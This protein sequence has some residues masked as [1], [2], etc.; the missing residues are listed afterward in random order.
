MKDFVP[1][2]VALAFTCLFLVPALNAQQ[3]DQKKDYF[4]AP[5][6]FTETT[7]SAKAEVLMK[8]SSNIQIDGTYHTYTYTFDDLVIFS[9]K[10]NT[11]I[12]VKNSSGKK[13]WEGVLDANEY[14]SLSPGA[15]I[16]GLESS[17]PFSII[18][19]DPIR[20]LVLGFHAMNEQGRGVGNKFLTYMPKGYFGQERFVI[21]SYKERNHVQIKDLSSNSIRWEGILDKGEFYSSA[22]LN[23]SFLQVNGSEDLSVLSYGDQGYLIPAE[24]GLWAGKNF[25]GYA[26]FVGQWPND[27]NII[28]FK[29]NSDIH[30]KDLNT[31][32]IIWSG[33]LNQGEVKSIALT[34]SEKKEVFFEITSD[35]KVSASISPFT[36]YSGNYYHLLDCVDETGLRIG[37]M[38]YLPAIN[39]RLDFSSFDD[40]NYV[41][42]TN[43]KTDEVEWSG[44]LQAGDHTSLGTTNS[45]YKIEGTGKLTGSESYGGSAGGSFVPVYYGLDLPDLSLT[46][47]SISFSPD[48]PSYGDEVTITANIA[49]RGN[50]QTS[51]IE[52]G[53]YDG[54][55]DMG[56][57]Q[58]GSI[59]T[60]GTI[61]ANGGTGKASLKWTAPEEPEH[62]QIYVV[63]D[64]NDKIDESNESNNKAHQPLIPNEDL[65]PPLAVTIAAPSGIELDK[66]GNYTPDPI[67]ITA[68]ISNSGDGTALGVYAT[69]EL[70]NGLTLKSGENTTHSLGEM[71]VDGHSS[72]TWEVEATGESNG[73]LTYTVEVGADNAEVKN[74][75]RLLHVPEPPFEADISASWQNACVGGADLY[76]DRG[77]GFEKVGTTGDMSEPV[78]VTNL[79]KGTKI[80]AVKKIHTEEAVKNGHEEVDD[81]MFELWVDSDTM[82]KDG[83]YGSYTIT[84]ESDSY[85]LEME[86]PVF[87]Y[88]LVLSAE[89]DIS[90]NDYYQKLKE[91][92]QLASKYLYNVTDG[93]VSFNKIAIYDNKEKWSNSDINLY[94]SQHPNATVN[95]IHL[96]FIPLISKLG[97]L[98]L[99]K[100]WDEYGNNAPHGEWPNEQ[101]YYTTIVHEFGHYAFA[102]YDEYEDG[103]G[104]NISNNPDWIRG[105]SEH[106]KNYG[107]MQSQYTYE[108][109]SSANDYLIYYPPDTPKDEITEQRDERGMPCWDWIKQKLEGYYSD[110]DIK[111]PPDG[112]YPD[113]YIKDREGPDVDRIREETHVIDLRAQDKKTLSAFSS[114]INIV[115]NE[116][117]V[118]AAQVYIIDNQER[119]YLGK[120]NQEGYVDWPGAHTDVQIRAYKI[121]QGRMVKK[122]LTIKEAKE[123]YVVKLDQSLET[124]IAKSTQGDDPGIV[125]DGEATYSDSDNII[126]IDLTLLAD[127]SLSQNPEATIYYGSASETVSFAQEGSTNKYTGSVNM[128]ATVSG[129]D[130]TG[131]LDVSIQDMDSNESSFTSYFSL[132]SLSTTAL[133]R[134]FIR[135]FNLNV[136]EESV[137]S[138]QIGIAMATHTLP[139]NSTNQSLYPV[140]E[141]FSVTFENYHSFEEEAGMN[142]SYQSSEVEGLDE[143]SLGLYKWN[144][145]DKKWDLL[146]ESQTNP[147][148]NVVSALIQST[149]IY[150][151]FATELSDDETLPGKVE[152]LSAKTGEGQANINLSWTAPGDDGMTGQAI[153]Y[154]IRFNEAPITHKNWSECQELSYKPNP[155]PAGSSQQTSVKMPKSNKLY[156]FALKT[157]DEAGNKSKLSNYTEAISSVEPYTFSL[158]SPAFN[159]TVETYSPRFEW[160]NYS[161][162]QDPLYTLI[163]SEDDQFVEEERVIDIA[164]NRYDQETELK[165]GTTYYWKVYTIESSSDTAW[166]NQP[167]FKFHT[168][169]KY[170][171][172]LNV[173]PSPGGSVSGEG[174]YKEG[175]EITVSAEPDQGY[176]FESW[177]A[178]EQEVSTNKDYTFTVQDDISLTANFNMVSAIHSISKLQ[179]IEVYPNPAKSHVIVKIKG[180]RKKAEIELLNIEGKALYEGIIPPGMEK[181]QINLDHYLDGVYLIRLNTKD[182]V[183]TK[184][185]ILSRE[186]GVILI[187]DKSNITSFVMKSSMP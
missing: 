77:Q 11:E 126:S 50:N 76:V 176:E 13:I 180:L 62:R 166:S 115:Y 95:G 96:P 186:F 136:E 36:S 1:K 45:L 68:N 34:S 44:K 48:H 135:G 41:E 100:K 19:G 39:G 23:N 184:K 70:P 61:S 152:D 88:N 173:N 130:G 147:G 81:T 55:P 69:L 63:A 86:H 127:A 29:D 6:S 103:N 12:A 78:H 8:T 54:D 24:S 3:E 117:P 16:Y 89:F 71:P 66:E 145:S 110:V 118:P 132:Q 113:G 97:K 139:Y 128:D 51:Q 106:P 120:T 185:F 114:R 90:D 105:G 99:G 57:V 153:N 75:N 92:F 131:Y 181:Y 109:A 4:G 21:F 20:G 22:N 79:S 137:P 94:A 169:P 43:L 178:D 111:M 149:G 148:K 104:E 108:E 107:L 60:I 14:N 72:T 146:T 67:E 42:I 26:G 9:Y 156:Y 167:Y 163:Y 28:S 125:L 2:I 18:T 168:I 84:S 142:I 174:S 5:P 27:L 122:L 151:V 58:I 112:Y 171:V 158:S 87:K 121:I 82:K 134:I 187:D 47:S 138:E 162:Q 124:K 56:G 143:T 52:V 144:A 46:T 80:K 183:Y 31:N 85:T 37:E 123:K 172:T 141:M 91:G 73:D 15:G 102:L 64:P 40:D 49:N 160:E 175:T 154:I 35:K 65:E 157:E 133:N 179:D 161:G 93:Q 182:H 33:N 83:S 119:M 98:N 177:T 10:D 129:F 116:K 165:D 32:Q 140:T 30:V 155:L 164:N 17:N 53:F 7:P 59:Q 25:Y 38:F 159:D 170:D 74:V 101:D 150:A